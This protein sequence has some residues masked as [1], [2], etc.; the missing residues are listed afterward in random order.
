MEV[1]ITQESYYKKARALMLQ[2]KDE[3][4]ARLVE[5]DD[6]PSTRRELRAQMKAIDY[7]VSILDRFH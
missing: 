1:V 7:C 3:L 5:L 2:R 4:K 6:K